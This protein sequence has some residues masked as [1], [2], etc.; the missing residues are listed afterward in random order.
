M[1]AFGWAS[2]LKAHVKTVHQGIK[3]YKCEVCGKAFAKKADVSRHK[4]QVHDINDYKCDVCSKTF[5]WGSHLRTHIKTVHNG[6]KNYQCNYCA[7]TFGTAYNLKQHIKSVHDKIFEQCETCGK[8]FHALAQLKRHIQSVHS[9]GEKVKSKKYLCDLCGKDFYSGYSRKLHIKTV[10]EKIKEFKCQYCDKEFGQKHDL[11]R[12]SKLVHDAD[13]LSKEEID[14]LR[15]RKPNSDFFTKD[16]SNF[17]NKIKSKE[18][19]PVTL[20]PPPPLEKLTVEELGTQNTIVDD[21]DPP[22]PPPALLPLPD[23]LLPLPDNLKQDPEIPEEENQNGFDNSDEVPVSLDQDWKNESSTIEVK[24]EVFEEEEELNDFDN[25]SIHSPCILQIKKSETPEDDFYVD[26]DGAPI[27]CDVEIHSN[28]EDYEMKDEQY[29]SDHEYKEEEIDINKPS[30]I[31]SEIE[32]TMATENCKNCRKSFP[33]NS[34]LKHLS[35]VKTCRASYDENEFRS[36][37]ERCKPDVTKGKTNITYFCKIFLS[38]DFY[39]CNIN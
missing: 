15:H 36:L 29:Y 7:K 1:K 30:K 17:I 25:V 19:V 20:L 12:H 23:N 35:H 11:F 14:K 2:H 37:E 32:V 22:A 8:V 3:G 5:G 10:H 6:I 33:L 27:N 31:D 16:D 34:I 39:W 4:K 13:E 21:E 24:E 26:F 18:T 38:F 9:D 28:S